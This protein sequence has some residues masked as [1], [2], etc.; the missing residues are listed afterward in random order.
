MFCSVIKLMRVIIS[1]VKRENLLAYFLTYV[2]YMT[3]TIS[4]NLTPSLASN[5]HLSDYVTQIA[6][7]LS[8]FMF[9]VSAILFATLSDVFTAKRVLFFSQ[10]LSIFGLVCIGLSDSIYTVYIGFVSLGLGTGCYSSI[11]RALI[12]R[13]A[14]NNSQMKKAYSVLS[15]MIIVAPIVSTYLALLLIPVSW[16]AAYFCMA[17][18]EVVLFIFSIK[19]LTADAQRQIVI[20]ASKIF[21]GFA[22]ALS[23]P[24]YL[25]NVMIVAILFSFYL[26]VLMSSFKGL[27]VDELNMSMDVFTI[28][29]LVTSLLYILGIFSYRIKADSSHKKRYNLGIL[30]IIFIFIALYSFL[31]ISSYST[32][33][34]LHLICYFLGFF[35]PMATGAAMSNITKGHGTAAA[36]ITFSVALCMSIWGFLKAHFNMSNYHFILLAL[37]ISFS[38]ALLLKIIIVFGIDRKE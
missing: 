24:R 11:A 28:V 26:G 35:I 18:I 13:N 16:R 4:M 21:S 8:F 29:F 22:H 7:S 17:T 10:S 15:V 38:L 19:I 23:Q 32:V 27:L 31:E 3:L 37:W 33:T 9:S 30:A 2:G 36:M 20:P 12:S 25:L 14:D 5:L 34:T 1:G 6:M